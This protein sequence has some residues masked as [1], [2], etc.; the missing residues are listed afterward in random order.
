M[1]HG[2]ES[3]EH[4]HMK[5]L[6]AMLF[7]LLGWI[8][9]FEEQLVDLVVWKCNPAGRMRI[10]AIELERTNQHAVCNVKKDLSRQ[11]DSVVS[12]VLNERQRS[13][14]RRKLQQGLPREM[15]TKVGI[16]TIGQI[17]E[18]VEQLENSLASKVKSVG[19]CPNNQT[20]AA[21]NRGRISK[22]IS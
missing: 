18:R 21:G 8:V 9:L 13:A 15:W 1:K 3:S 4:I 5:K 20:L 10:L 12:V 14:L 17:A 11:C 19:D 22:E 2:H 6:I 16:V 7:T